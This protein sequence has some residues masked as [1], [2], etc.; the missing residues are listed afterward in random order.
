[1]NRIF[2]NLEVQTL[3]KKK[4]KQTSTLTTRARKLCCWGRSTRLGKGSAPESERT[5]TQQAFYYPA[6]C[7]RKLS[8]AAKGALPQVV[9]EMWP[10]LRNQPLHGSHTVGCEFAGWRIVRVL[11]RL[12]H[13]ISGEHVSEA[14]VQPGL[15]TR[16]DS[17][18]DKG[19]VL[20][21]IKS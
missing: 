20:I 14:W 6:H 15:Q 2:I 19:V 18:T 12:S 9:Q 1:M 10:G 3:K 8:P 4:T 7:L 16:R 11:S 21:H 13:S 5:L 17:K